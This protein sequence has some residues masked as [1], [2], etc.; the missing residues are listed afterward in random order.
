MDQNYRNI[1]GNQRAYI[2]L[3]TFLL[4]A[5]VVG[6]AAAHHMESAG[7]R[8]TGM[9]NQVVW[10][11]PH[12]FAIAL[13]LAASGAANVAS[14]S[15]VFGNKIYAPWARL[16]G[17]SAICLLIGGLIV[18]VLDLGRPDRLIIAMT[19]YNFR[20]IFTWNIFLYTGFVAVVVMYLWTMFER[21]ASGW[22][23]KAG[24]VVLVWR[25]VL[26]TGTGSIFGFLVARQL[27][28]S[29]ML[30]PI[31]IVLSL[32]LGTAAL[33]LI[34]RLVQHWAIAGALTIV[35]D[36]LVD[37]LL[38]LTGFFIAI[39]CLLVAAFY[40]TGLYVAERRDAAVFILADGGVYTALF[41]VG[42]ILL[43]SLIPLW[44]IFGRPQRTVQSPMLTSSF[45]FLGACCHLYVVIIGGQVVPQVL[46]PGKEVSSSFYDG[47]IASYSPSVYELLLGTGG[48]ALA[49]LILLVLIRILPFLP[50]SRVHRVTG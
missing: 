28:N 15:S 9:N 10:G 50:E 20:S 2:A 8:V 39:E 46:F 1:D 21:H 34:L 38:R 3:V 23:S 32:V 17:I 22:T 33:L 42:Q 27:Y 18:L 49:L 11:L 19:H 44:L 47:V 14:M 26:T 4:L 25:L 16:S 43:G 29:A 40:L 41:W 31:F 36:E 24:M 5:V 37:R 7:H 12:V 48:V 45:I 13:V 35:T 30:A 6:Y